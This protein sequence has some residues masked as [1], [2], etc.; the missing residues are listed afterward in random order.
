MTRK[1][2]KEVDFYVP[3]SAMSAGTVLEMSGDAI[4][5]DYYSLLGPIDPQ[6]QRPDGKGMIPALGYLAQYE[7]LIEKDRR[8][9][10]TTAEAQ[11]LLECF[12]QGE[13]HAFEQARELTVTLLK[14]WL[15]TFKFKNWKTTAGRGLPVT[16]AMKEERAAEIARTL[17]DTARWHS[18]S[19][20]IPMEVM[21]RDLNL[22]VEDFGKIP[23]LSKSIRDYYKLL[24]D[25]RERRGHSD[26]LHVT[27]KYAHIWEG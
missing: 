2:Y 3:D 26:V 16:D 24:N 20:G 5:M 14:R 17:N 4:H 9:I 19:R 22:Q 21:R 27:E 8:G 12:D 1:Y 6:V 25:Y 11:I 13:L 15:T 23:E 18:H 7:R 10:L